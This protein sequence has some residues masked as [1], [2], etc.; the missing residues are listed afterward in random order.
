LWSRAG[1]DVVQLDTHVARVRD[2]GRPV[3]LDDHDGRPPEL[4]IE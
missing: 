2:G 3:I 4:L 1:A